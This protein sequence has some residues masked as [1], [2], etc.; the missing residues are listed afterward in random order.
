[1]NSEDGEQGRSIRDRIVEL[2]RM[3]REEQQANR[4]AL[5][6]QIHG[7][8]HA[9]KEAEHARNMELARQ[10]N[11]IM[12]QK[13]EE[14][15]E[16][17][18][19]FKDHLAHKMIEARQEHIRKHHSADPRR[20]LE[21]MQDQGDVDARKG[22]LK[23]HIMNA[24]SQGPSHGY[25]MIQ[26][27][28]IHTGGL[29]TPSPGSMYPALESLESGGFISCKGDGRRKIYSLTPKGEE[30]LVQIQKKHQVQFLEMK[31]FLADI[32]GE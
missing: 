9:Q 11:E 6:E 26:N 14:D 15:S 32:F 8:M 13:Y 30:A 2:K 4:K 25:E 21:F 23:L 5:Q 22:F 12:Q 7:I 24:L 27:I 17:K 10:I 16:R 19:S 31:A 18:K 3:Q 28:G 20:R 1:M 29:W